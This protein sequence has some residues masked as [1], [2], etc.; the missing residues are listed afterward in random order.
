MKCEYCWKHKFQ[1]A[2]QAAREYR[3]TYKVAC[4]EPKIHIS[5]LPSK[6]YA[7]EVQFTTKRASFVDFSGSLKGRI[8]FISWEKE[9]NKDDNGKKIEK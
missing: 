9:K 8:V 7:L 5:E 1:D 6:K 3:S 4:L 2:R